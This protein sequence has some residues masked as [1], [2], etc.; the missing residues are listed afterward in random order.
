[1]E[2][3]NQIPPGAVQ[4]HF[5]TAATHWNPRGVLQ[6]NSLSADL[7][8]RLEHAHESWT[9]DKYGDSLSSAEAAEVLVKGLR[10]NV[11]AAV[12]EFLSGI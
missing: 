4:V 3:V 11:E 1:M 9:D 7:L 5:G 12:E 8:E 10:H 6:K 2:F